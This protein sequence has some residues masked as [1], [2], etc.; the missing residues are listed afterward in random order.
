MSTRARRLPVIPA[1]LIALLV[2]VLS[3]CSSGAAT[4]IP[5][6]ATVSAVPA[7]SAS[8]TPEVTAEPTAAP[9]FPVTLTDD[10]G[11]VVELAAEPEHI[12]SLSPANT[13]ILFELGVG[14]R[15]VATD[16]ASDTPAEAA[17]LPDVT[18]FEGFTVTV[19]VERIV[20]LETDLVVAAGL[21]F[22][23]P[24]AVT[25]LRGLGIPVVVVYAPTVD[26]VYRD[27][28]L[29]GTAVGASEAA[30]AL[31]GEMREEIDAISKA[32]AAAGTPP[33]V[34]YEIGY[35]GTTGA[36]YAPAD[37]S[38]VA[39]MVTLAGGETITTGD[40]NSYEIP[41]EVLITADP[42]V[43]VLGVNAFYKPTAEEVLARPG[44]DVMTAV[45]DGDIR[46]VD[47]T[48]ITRPGPRLPTGLRNLAAVIW[49]DIELP[50]P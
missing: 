19:D 18:A 2:A 44:W 24:E 21:G 4:S 46:I 3:A 10:E 30:A 13:E 22:T 50:A 48:E 8:P 29:I 27:I 11:T 6:D 15:V 31:T 12:V 42:E 47:D 23:P 14:D 45:R 26:A 36:I 37:D 41:L 40:P 43:I 5:P 34:F 9:A 16:N 20:E 38:F 25:Q 39:E 17:A 1:F 28:E 32:V 33:R 35:D 7:T 49:P